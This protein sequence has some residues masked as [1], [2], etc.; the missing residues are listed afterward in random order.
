MKEQIEA[1]KERISLSTMLGRD[2]KELT[3]QLDDLLEKY[4]E[5]LN[6]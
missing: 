6:F 3:K 5:S 2:S 1:I 4:V